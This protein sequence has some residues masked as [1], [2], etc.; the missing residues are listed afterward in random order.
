M[1]GHLSAFTLDAL[2]V[3]ALGGDDEA[4]TREHLAA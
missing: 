4:R 1:T 2:A 3:G